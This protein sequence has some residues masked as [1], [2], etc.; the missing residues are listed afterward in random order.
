MAASAGARRRRAASLGGYARMAQGAP[1]QLD[2][3]RRK[4]GATRGAQLRG[5]SEWG[6]RMAEARRLKR[7]GPG[8]TTE[9]RLRDLERRMLALESKEEARDRVNGAG[10]AITTRRTIPYGE[11][12]R[13]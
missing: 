4:A 8:L 2:E 13:T 3:M 12:Q 5:D 9:Q 10:E 1:L 6:R 7:Y 11:P